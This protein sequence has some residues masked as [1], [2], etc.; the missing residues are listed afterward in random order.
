MSIE[1]LMDKLRKQEILIRKLTRENYMMHIEIGRLL[2]TIIKIKGK[3]KEWIKKKKPIIKIKPIIEIED[4]EEKIPC[5][6]CGEILSEEKAKYSIKTCSSF[7]FS[8]YNGEK[9]T[10]LGRKI[11]KES[12]KTFKRNPDSGIRT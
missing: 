8:Y 6:C 2:D 12:S 9:L 7:C 5:V 10:A 11:V 4:V 3:P 1:N